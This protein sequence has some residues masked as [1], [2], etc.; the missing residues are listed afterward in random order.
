M[1]PIKLYKFANVDSP[2]L[3]ATIVASNFREA[4]EALQ[5]QG[6]NPLMLNLVKEANLTELVGIQNKVLILLDDL[7]PF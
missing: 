4:V 1:N 5:V 6:H 2:N 3:T 7:L